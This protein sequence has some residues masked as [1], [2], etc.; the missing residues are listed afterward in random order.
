MDTTTLERL[1]AFRHAMYTTLGCRRD[2]LVEIL[3]ALLTTP[4]IRASR[5]LEPRSWLPTQLGPPLRC[6]Q[7]RHHAA[8][9][10]RTACGRTAVRDRHGV[11]CRRCECLAT[12][13][14]RNQPTARVL[15]SSLTSFQRAA[16][17]RWLELLLARPDPRTLLQLDR[18]ARGCGGCSRERRSIRWR[19]NRFARA[20]HQYGPGKPSPVFTFDA[21]YEPVQLGVALVGLDVSVLVRLRSGR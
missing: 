7:R 5:P 8:A 1:R 3:D 10:L 13:R 6:A 14:C 21:G 12:L 15:S 4:G 2:A 20:S 11:V 17:C 9:S 19:R 16:H 18:E